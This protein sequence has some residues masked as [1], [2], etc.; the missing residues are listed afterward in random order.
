MAEESDVVKL[1]KS[2]FKV[3]LF[4]LFLAALSAQIRSRDGI[5]PCSRPRRSF[6]GVHCLPKSLGQ[7]LLC[8]KL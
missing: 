1:L 7:I 6:S 2:P 3:S 5:W 4:G 8:D